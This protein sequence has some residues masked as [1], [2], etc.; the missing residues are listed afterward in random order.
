[1]ADQ[2]SKTMVKT[3]V[4]DQ[5]NDA[6]EAIQSE[7]GYNKSQAVNF[8]LWEGHT[9]YHSQEEIEGFKHR[10]ADAEPRGV[11]ESAPRDEHDDPILKD[12]E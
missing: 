7:F 1:M 9:A 5:L 2:T 4:V 6:I 11:P 8:L 10:L 12:N 3:E